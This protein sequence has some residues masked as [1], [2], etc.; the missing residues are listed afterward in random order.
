MRPGHNSYQIWGGATPA[1]AQPRERR[2]RR[3][4]VA[5]VLLVRGRPIYDRASTRSQPGDEISHAAPA[6]PATPAA[7]AQPSRRAAPSDN[8]R[9]TVVAANLAWSGGDRETATSLYTAAAEQDKADQ[10]AQAA[11]PFVTLDVTNG[12]PAAPNIGP[13]AAPGGYVYRVDRLRW[14]GRDRGQRW[15]VGTERA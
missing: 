1:H 2:I 7:P 10:E 3:H 14:P 8:V 5:P 15:S 13:P 4:H 12:A 9:R 11:A 6:T